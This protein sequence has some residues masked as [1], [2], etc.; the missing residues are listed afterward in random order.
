MQS[1][2]VCYDIT[3]NKGRRLI[4]RQLKEFG[5]RWQ[6][7]VFYCELSRSDLQRLKQEIRGVISQYPKLYKQGHDSIIILPICEAC[8]GKIQS[9]LSK[10]EKET[11]SIYI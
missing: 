1:I 10:H 9:Y 8:H 3:S 2:L 7:S 6:Y 4:E 5:S 11:K